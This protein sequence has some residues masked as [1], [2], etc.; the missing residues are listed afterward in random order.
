MYLLSAM[1]KGGPEPEQRFPKG[2]CDSPNYTEAF[3]SIQ[4]PSSLQFIAFRSQGPVYI[5]SSISTQ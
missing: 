3:Y 4:E 5:Y 1:Q 2:A